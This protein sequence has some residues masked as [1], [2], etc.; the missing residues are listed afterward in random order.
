VCFSI[1]S[2]Y[3]YQHGIAKASEE[4]AKNLEKSWQT[5]L[6]LFEVLPLSLEGAKW[7]GKI[8][9]QYEKQT[10]IGEKE[11][12][13]HTVDFILAGTALETDAII[14]SDDGIFRKIKE[15]YPALKV[16]NWK[17]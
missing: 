7:Y 16:E 5:F 13:R 3:E 6:D 11:V 8:K 12:K 1:L 9:T 15:F 10:G 17:E 2:A 14:V 4:L